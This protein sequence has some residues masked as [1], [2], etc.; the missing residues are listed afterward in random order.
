MLYTAKP[1]LLRMREAQSIEPVAVAW[2]TPEE[3]VV[4]TRTGKLRAI[5]DRRG[6]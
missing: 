1:N 5:V 2:I 3:L 6:A 4:N